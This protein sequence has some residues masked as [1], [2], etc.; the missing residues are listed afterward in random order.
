MNKTLI[1]LI[2][3]TSILILSA[4][5]ICISPIINNIEV[6]LTLRTWSPKQWRNLNCAIFA[7][8]EKADTAKLDDL[9]KYKKYKNICYRQKAMY[10]LENA[11]FIINIVL[12]FVCAD[13]TLLHYLNV[14]KDFEKKTGLIG[15]ISGIIGFILTLV[16]V[17]FSGYIFTNDIAYGILDSQQVDFYPPTNLI[18][19]YP[20]GAKYKWEGSND[21]SAGKF[22]TVY[23]NDKEE[24]SNYLLY[25]DLGKKQYNYN[26]EFYETYT[27]KE[28]TATNINECN[29]NSL[30]NPPASG[31][32]C[33]YL[34]YT[35]IK[36]VENKYIYDTWLTS[37]ILAVLIVACNLV[38]S[39]F[40]FLLFKSNE[41][42]APSSEQAP[43]IYKK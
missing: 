41:E 23:E 36:T 27:K 26:S 14:G 43:I 6:D 37:L 24:N 10:G 3:S 42:I 11:A 29:I 12:A 28:P 34:Y 8:K 2:I 32:Q 19:L 33:E 16:Y 39:Y 7:D 18:K 15:I 25:K 22:I 38:L 40:G 4:V 5:V 1:F 35:P 21:Y 13:L 17:C 20:N 9:Q 30:Y 31:L